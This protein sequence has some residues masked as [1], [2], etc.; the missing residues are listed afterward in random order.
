MV[1]KQSSPSKKLVIVVVPLAMELN[2]TARCEIDLSPGTS[3]IPDITPVIGRKFTLLNSFHSPTLL[4]FNFQWLLHNHAFRSEEH[5]S[6]LQS[7]FDLVC[8]H[9]LEK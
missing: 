7:R 3:I 6:E 8:R 1:C 4:V 9:L 2:M 5:T